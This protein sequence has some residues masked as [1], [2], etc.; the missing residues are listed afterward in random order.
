MNKL[1]SRF[2]SLLIGL[3]TAANVWA[4][5]FTAVYAFGDSL[6]DSGSSPSAV[7]SIYDFGGG[8]CDAY[9][10]CPPYYEG[11]YSNGP[12]TVEYLADAILAGGATSTNFFDFA[13]SGSTSGIGN[14]GDGGTATS[15]GIYGLPGMYQQVGFYLTSSGGV[16]DPDALYFVWGG[17][18]DFLTM[19]DPVNAALNIASY[20]GALAMAGAESIF[21]PNIADLALVPFVQSVGLEAEGHAFS[22]AFNTALETQLTALDALFPAVDIMRFDTFAL[23]NDVVANPSSYGFTDVFG[24]CLP[25]LVDPPCADPD[26]YVSWD[27]FHPTTRAASVIASAM[28]NSIPA[29]ATLALLAAGL[30]VLPGVGG[31]RGICSCRQA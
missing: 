24:A 1:P 5:S 6:S 26:G 12:V 4:T 10:P 23:F 14:Y 22:V 13:V 8:T 25:T 29:P 19:D 3:L 18:N 27:G 11:R 9:H 30:F 2:V 16:A 28:A 20:V 17:A 21:V 15:T 31:R 7:W